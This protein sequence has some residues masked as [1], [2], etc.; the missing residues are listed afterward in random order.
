MKVSDTKRKRNERY[1]SKGNETTII[2]EQNAGG[3]YI[4]AALNFKIMIMK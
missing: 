2:D 3:A 4:G 1:K